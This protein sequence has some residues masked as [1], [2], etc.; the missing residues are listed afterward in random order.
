MAETMYPVGYGRDK[1]TMAVLE[2]RYGPNAS[3][4]AHPEY[5]QRIKAWLI[6]RGGAMGIGGAYRYSQPSG[7][8]FAPAGKSF[9][10]KQTFASGFA[11][12]SAIDL[13]HVNGSNVHRAP[14]WSEVPKQGSGHPDIKD[15]GL[16]CNVSDEPWHIQA[17]EQ[18]GYQSWVNN[19]RPD[20][21]ADYPIKGGSGGGGTGG[22]GGG[23]GGSSTGNDTQ[24]GPRTAVPTI[25]EGDWGAGVK[26]IQDTCNFWGWGNV[27]NADGK[28]GPRTT[29]GVKA[30][31]R[32]IKV[33]ADGDYGP[34]TRKALEAFLDAMD[35]LAGGDHAPGS[36]TLVKQSPQM[37]GDDVRYFQ[38]TAK[39][40]GLSIT[41]DGNYG[42]ESERACK[43]I[44]GWNGLT[45]DGRCGPDTWKAV[46][47]YN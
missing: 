29:D 27:G 16:H 6:S 35:A 4:P 2:A 46:K 42:S 32:A 36:R 34:A 47:A 30:M 23:G 21:R 18:D 37:S 3:I 12:Y 9:H 14:Y 20:P 11:G 7:P 45:K 28:F 15:Y 26:Q 40:Q 5:W 41:V 44:Q 1:V 13:V 8:T 39:A 25:V 31:Q 24:A 43:S 22:G 10:E 33:T 17:I 38:T 19:G